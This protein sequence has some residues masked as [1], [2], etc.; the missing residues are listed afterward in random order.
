MSPSWSDVAI[1]FAP[2]L[3]NPNNSIPFQSQ[4]KNKE[5][6]RAEY[7]PSSN[8]VRPD[9][10]FRYSINTDDTMEDAEF[11]EEVSPIVLACQLERVEIVNLLFAKCSPEI[12]PLSGKC[13]FT[14]LN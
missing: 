1:A 4:Q 2:K 8:Y 11:T 14:I 3:T 13:Y 12:H 5:K 9:K 7:K 6:R 10:I